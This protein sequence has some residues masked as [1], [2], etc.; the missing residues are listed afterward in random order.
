MLKKTITYTDYNGNERTEDFYFNLTESEVNEKNLTTPGGYL[1]MIDRVVKAQDAPSLIKVFK[2]F[3]LDAY[4][5]KSEDGRRFIK[6]DE[7]RE[8]FSQTEAYNI[9]FMELA[10]DDKKASEFVNGVLPNK[11]P[12]NVSSIPA[13]KQ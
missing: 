3:I 8:A 1:E 13:P 7:V 12:A 11:K 2:E 5:I 4:G 9:M 6:N 10:T